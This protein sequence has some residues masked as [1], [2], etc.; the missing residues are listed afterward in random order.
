MDSKARFQQLDD[1]IRTKMRRIIKGRIDI[2]VSEGLSGRGKRRSY[3]WGTSK[4]IIR[5]INI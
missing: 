2:I 4:I 3:F 1:I 5:V